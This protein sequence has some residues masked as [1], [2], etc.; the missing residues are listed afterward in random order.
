M[1][2]HLDFPFY[3]R[4]GF[5]VIREFFSTE[6]IKDIEYH[7]TEYLGRAGPAAAPTTAVAARVFF[8]MDFIGQVRYPTGQVRG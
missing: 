8:V 5:A 3:R 2:P 1:S 7:V 4:N 6:E